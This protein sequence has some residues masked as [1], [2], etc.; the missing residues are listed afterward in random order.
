[1]TRQVF[2]WQPFQPAVIPPSEIDR[3]RREYGVAFV[4]RALLHPFEVFLNNRYQVMKRRVPDQSGR[5][6]PDLIHLSIRRLDRQPIHDWRDLQRI[7]N[8]LVGPEYEAIELYPAE[9]RRV[10]AANQFHLWCVEDPTYRFPFGFSQRDVQQDP[11]GS[12]HQRPFASE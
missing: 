11:G 2:R 9:S 3:V 6:L 12:A 7:K 4:E 5:G 10:D 8:E 1:M